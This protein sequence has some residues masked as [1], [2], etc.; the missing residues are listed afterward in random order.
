VDTLRVLSIY[1]GFF[2]GGARELHTTVIRELHRGGGHLH[3]VLSLHR[4]VLRESLLQTIR[5]DARCRALREVG[6]RVAT[7]GRPA[8]G[9]DP[10]SFSEPEIASAAR[11]AARNDLI[12][13]LKEQPLHLVNQAGFPE[14]PVVVCLHRSD[15]QNQGRA[16]TALLSVI[17]AGRVAA[18]VCCAESTRDAYLRAG[19]PASLLTVVPNG[20]DLARFRPVSARTRRTLRR[21]LGVPVG[22]ELVVFAARHDGMK[23]VPLF[24]AAARDFL[25]RRRRGHIVMCGAGMSLSNVDLCGQLDRAF[26]DR[27]DLLRRL[28]TLGVRQDMP[29][30]YAAADVVALTSSSGEAAPLCLIEGMMCGAVPVATDVGDCARIVEGRGILC[31]PDPAA[32]SA[33]W[34]EAIARRSEW[35][36]VLQRSRPQ[37][38]HTRMASLYAAV[39][40]RSAESRT[41]TGKGA[42]ARAL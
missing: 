3:S 18:V 12:L 34:T 15:P 14:R 35:T 39:I 23:N 7:L 38:C 17:G 22:A 8:H 30:I 6:I 42:L 27:P 20:V 40:D 2:A 37:F 11:H 28:H 24:L 5:S 29:S 19:V 26:A 9:A 41:R 16:L 32:I 1:E 10:T 21:D 33:A 36:P 31:E 4:A 13:S 25:E